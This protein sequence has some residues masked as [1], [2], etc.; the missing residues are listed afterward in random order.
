MLKG[1]HISFSYH[2]KLVIDDIDVTIQ[3]GKIYGF[4]GRNGSGKTT[5][6][7]VLNGLLKPQKGSVTVETASKAL[8]IYKHSKA[9]IAKEIGFVPQES[10]GVF[11]YRVLEM[12]VM[13]RNPHLG[14]F[15]RPKDEDYEVAMEALRL[16]GIDHLSEKNFMEISGGERQLVLI[17]R[18]IAQGV[19]YLIL[20]EPTS[21][22]DFNNQH[23]IM[24]LVKKISKE[25]NVA[26][27]MAIHD[28]NLA[29]T[30]ADY[31]LMLKNGK[32]MAEGTVEEVMTEDNLRTLYDMDINIKGL[33]DER[34]Y[35]LPAI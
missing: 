16:I 29:I 12:V 15:E 25:R 7:K 27:I 32:L 33:S 6:L 17:A 9:L 31:I 24:K 20:D 23:Q 1:E 26:A 19:K 22:L 2:N 10:R 13:G 18:V 11:P 8:N 34:L 35:V 28:P 4:L 3:P 21:H 5:M 14:Y 30:F